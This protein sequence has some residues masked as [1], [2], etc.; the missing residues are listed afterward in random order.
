MG[1]MCATEK[2]LYINNIYYIGSWKFGVQTCNH[3]SKP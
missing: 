2:D 3:M 1:Y